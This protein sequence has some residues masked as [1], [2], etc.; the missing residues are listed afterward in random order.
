VVNW[1]SDGGSDYS[2]AYNNG[3][4]NVSIDFNICDYTYRQC[5]DKGNTFVNIINENNT[6]THLSSNDIS[7][8]K[9]DLQDPYRPD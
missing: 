3:N 4:G 1:C 2:V 5:P 7:D 9:V 6:C 8:V